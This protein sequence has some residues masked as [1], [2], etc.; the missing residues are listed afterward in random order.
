MYMAEMMVARDT[1]HNWC[2]PLYAALKFGT[3]STS[4]LVR[5]QGRQ[6]FS[7]SVQR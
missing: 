4:N 6:Q 7:S 5:K 3:M 2:N 1:A